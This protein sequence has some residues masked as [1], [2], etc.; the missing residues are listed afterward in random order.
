MRCAVVLL[1]LA[2]F[3]A[4]I[5][6]VPKQRAADQELLK[7][8]QDCILLL[9]QITQPIPNEQLH[10]LGTS[11]DI[12]NNYHQF[13]NPILVKYYVGAVRAGLVQPKG[14]VYSNSVS[15]LRKEVALLHRILLG[16]KNYQTFLNTAAWARVHVNE[17]QFVKAFIG[18]VLQR[19]DMQG[20]ILPPLYEIIPH[21]YFDSRIIQEAQDVVAQQHQNVGQHTYVQNGQTYVV[22]PVNYSSHLPH[23]EHQLSHFTQD[24]GLAN[25]YGM[26]NLAGYL[27]QQHGPQQTPVQ[28]LQQ[29]I[30]QEQED[31]NGQGS[32]YYYIHR[33]LLA[34]Y[35]LS[36]LGAGLGPIYDTD[37]THVKAP[38]QPHFRFMNGL[39]FPGRP[40]YLQ[41]SAT[42][43]NHLVKLVKLIEQRL[44]NAIDSGHV[45]TPQG[46]FLSLYQPQGLNILGEI[47]EG[48]GR[49]INPRYYGSFQAIGR[50]LFGNA[51]KVQNIYDYTPSVLELGQTAVRDPAFYQLYK[52]IIGLFQRYQ[53]SL[54]A[55]QYNDVLLHGVKIQNVQVSQ[56]MTFF[57]DYYVDLD[58]ATP[59]NVQQQHQ[60]QQPE[61]LKQHVQGQVKRL[62]HKPYEY[63]VTVQS[64]R[65][66]PGCVVRVF[67]GP[68]YDYDGKPISISKH[69]QQFVELD[70]FVTDLQ[71]GQN[72][73]TRNSHQAPGLSFDYPSVQEIKQCVGNAIRSQAP[74]YVTEPHQ[75]YGFPA[76][77]A[78]PK[79]H[80]EGY[81]LQWLVVIS[82]P[83]QQ[84]V[85]YGP[86]VPEQYQTY[87][88]SEYQVVDVENYP[89]QIQQHT[90][91]VV[92]TKPTVEVVPETLPI[93]Q[94]QSQVVRN[95]YANI[96]TQQHGQYPYTHTQYNVGQGQGQTVW[97]GVQTGM[98]GQQYYGQG[99]QQY[100]Q[101]QQQYQ[102]QGIYQGQQGQVQGQ[103]PYQY[104][105]EQAKV[106]QKVQ[107]GVPTS[108]PSVQ[109][110]QGRMPGVETA[111]H[112]V[113]TEGIHSG[114]HGDV[115]Q[116]KY[117]GTYQGQSHQ[118]QGYGVGYYGSGLY[119]AGGYQNI[120]GQGQKVQEGQVNEYYQGKH[121]SEI[122]GGA[123]SLDGKPYGY[124]LNRPLTPGAL[125]V[126]NVHI[127]TVYVYHEGQPTNE[128]LYQ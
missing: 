14:T 121:I 29:G 128:V 118:A 85:P 45:L 54:P 103:V 78:L 25:Y 33:Q 104:L 34:R 71:Q 24:I 55:Y 20:I 27:L 126:P 108:V 10:I 38:Y 30:S 88:Q 122:I 57:N 111:R 99:Q 53:D 113:Q 47:I 102:T 83:G 67:L 125:F 61:T 42:K 87:Q 116:G 120:F 84:N 52:K 119:H 1:A 46:A 62:D 26:V 65:N 35:E 66:I 2:A 72:V 31:N 48:T 50:Q 16:A 21:Y 101:G 44:T 107:G 89:Q 94:Q 127:Q 9:Q 11:Y 105:G 74:F 112:V 5:P 17:E 77:L 68:K 6:Q 98:Q 22:I 51:P 109:N 117:Q 39:E 13:E 70:Q 82:Q 93:G 4:A 86:V 92:G 36:R 19:P 123:V 18:A 69:R 15:Q 7:K 81:P 41:L 110:V 76:R 124:P 79:G 97:Q 8:Q 96:Y 32:R 3:G 106:G 40:E 80:R 63:T 58:Q 90:T 56:L 49:S 114:L 100:V 37:Y 73:I 12:E 75:V 95:H 64:E 43:S 59:H 60:Q 91:K 115:Q 28:Y 23:G